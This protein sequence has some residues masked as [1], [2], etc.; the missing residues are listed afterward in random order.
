MWFYKKNIEDTIW[1]VRYEGIVGRKDFTFDKKRFLVF[2]RIIHRICPRSK[3]KSLTGKNRIGQ[4]GIPEKESQ[5][6]RNNQSPRQEIPS[7]R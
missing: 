5:S 1:W 2:G 6:A 3:K 7:M 4:T